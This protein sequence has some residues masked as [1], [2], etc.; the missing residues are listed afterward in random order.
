MFRDP[1]FG[2]RQ[3][4]FRARLTDS[5][6]ITATVRDPGG[7]ETAVLHALT[8]LPRPDSAIPG[9]AGGGARRVWTIPARVRGFT[10]RAELLAELEAAARSGGRR[11]CRQRPGWAESARPARRSSTPTATTT[12]S[13]SPGGYPPRI[14]R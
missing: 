10:G 5:G 9:E 8:A 13:T 6:V 14:R 3:E 7:L 11:W 2:A 4:A 1:Q 12:S